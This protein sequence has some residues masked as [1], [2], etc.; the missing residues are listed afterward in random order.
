MQSL[1]HGTVRFGLS[2]LRDRIRVERVHR[3]SIQRPG[4]AAVYLPA[5]RHQ[6]FGAGLVGQQQI[7]KRRPRRS[8]EPPPFAGQHQN[9]RFG[10]A[11]SDHLRAFGQAGCKKLA[12]PRFGV[13]YGHDC[14]AHLQLTD[15]HFD[16]GNLKSEAQHPTSGSVYFHDKLSVRYS[17]AQSRKQRLIKLW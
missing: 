9:R 10:A 11:L 2:K 14:M 8:L 5:C 13:L 16:W 4:R 6:R 17:A 15:W 7:L 3:R 1:H 12:E